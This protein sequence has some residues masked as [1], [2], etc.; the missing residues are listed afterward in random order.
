M[1]GCNGSVGKAARA[2]T[3]LVRVVVLRKGSDGK[4]GQVVGGVSLV[5]VRVDR[6]GEEARYPSLFFTYRIL[7]APRVMAF[8]DFVHEHFI[9]VCILLLALCWVLTTPFDRRK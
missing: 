3:G 8:L 5:G 9:G 7:Y 1:V 4:A 2:W 6:Y